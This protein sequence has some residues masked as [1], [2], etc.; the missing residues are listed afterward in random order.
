MEYAI[1]L[2]CSSAFS[3]GVSLQT[4]ACLKSTIETIK[5]SEINSKLT[6]KTQNDVND[7]IMVSLLLRWLAWLIENWLL[8]TDLFII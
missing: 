1:F 2:F 6:T 7:A 3:E 5:V 4:F 8:Q